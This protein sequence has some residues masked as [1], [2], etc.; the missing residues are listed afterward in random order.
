MSLLGHHP[1][2]LAFYLNLLAAVVVFLVIVFLCMQSLHLFG[3]ISDLNRKSAIAG[4]QA[5]AILFAGL[6][7][8]LAIGMRAK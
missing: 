8:P 2:T 6:T 1:K 4:V 7:I 3:A 5:M